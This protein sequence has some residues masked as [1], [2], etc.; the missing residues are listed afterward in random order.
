[1]SARIAIATATPISTLRWD[2][3]APPV[4]LTVSFIKSSSDYVYSSPA[5]SVGLREEAGRL[6]QP[7]M[8]FLCIGDPL[9]VGIAGH[10]GLI[11]RAIAHQLL[12]LGR[13]A[14]FL[15]HID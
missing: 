12:P 10:E 5:R 13:L 4:S 3:P 1:M 7:F 11:E 8:Q 6:H 14:Y 9:H 2:G 15:E